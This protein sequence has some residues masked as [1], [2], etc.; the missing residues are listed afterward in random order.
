MLILLYARFGQL[1][2]KVVILRPRFLWPKDLNVTHSQRQEC[3]RSTH[4][5]RYHHGAR[6]LCWDSHSWL[7]SYDLVR[8]VLAGI[9][10][11]PTVDDWGNSHG[12]RHHHQA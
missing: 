7:S 2:R 8:A 5:L 1:R 6:H 12:L 3:P 11:G 9:T 10:R 4:G